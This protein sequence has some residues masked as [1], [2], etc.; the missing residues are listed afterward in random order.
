MAQ[1]TLRPILVVVA[2]LLML[3]LNI[4]VEADPADLAA[5]GGKGMYAAYRNAFAPHPF[6][7]AIWLPI[8]LGAI[9]FSL[10]QA[11]PSRQQDPRLRRAGGFA[12]LGY[13]MVGLTAL[14]PIGLSNIVVT[15]ALAAMVAALYATRAFDSGPERWLARAPTGLFAGWLLVATVLNLCQLLTRAAIRIDG[16]PAAAM[17]I[18]AALAGIDIMRRSRE[19]AVALA[20][21]WAFGGIVAARPAEGWIWAGTAAGLLLLGSRFRLPPEPAPPGHP[22]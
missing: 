2:L 12:A 8:F 16:P 17:I 21:I 3:L 13:L 10:F 14:V 22:A 11:L 7:F 4:G 9:A 5:Q 15:A 20:L 19:P 1:S 18:G 6:T